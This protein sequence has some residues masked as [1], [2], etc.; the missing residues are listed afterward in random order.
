MKNS[1]LTVTRTPHASGATVLTVAGEL[2]HHTASELTDTLRHTPFGPAAPVVIDLAE[3][4]YCDSTGITVLIRAYNQANATGSR[5]FLT[6]L[7]PDLA[8]VF[9]IVGLD[10]VFTFRPTVEEAL[11][12][13]AS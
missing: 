2:D 9:G 3:L 4:V 5:L 12:A 10:Q 13:L 6:G 11:A 1:A 8:H 7:R